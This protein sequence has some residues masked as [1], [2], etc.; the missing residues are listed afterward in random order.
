[1]RMRWKA[2]ALAATLLGASAAP[3][4]AQTAR[5]DVLVFSK[6]TGFRHT[7]AIDAGKAGLQAMGVEKNMAASTD[8]PAPSD[9]PIRIG[10]ALPPR[11]AKSATTL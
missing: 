9:T 11:A 1:M 2:V 7:D 10:L 3:A 6:T 8:N 4:A 5:Y